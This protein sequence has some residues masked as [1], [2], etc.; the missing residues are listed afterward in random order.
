[1]KILFL[2]FDGVLVPGPLFRQKPRAYAFDPVCVGRLNKILDKL[3]DMQVV[4]SSTWRK[5]VPLNQ[6]VIHLLNSGLDL[7][8][9]RRVIGVTPCLERC[10]EQRPRLAQKYQR[11]EE[12]LEWL[13]QH[14][15]ACEFVCI[16]DHDDFDICGAHLVK[17][18]FEDGLTEAKMQEVFDK[19][20]QF[21]KMN[22]EYGSI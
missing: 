4:I 16:D 19:F 11:G 17:T 15:I 18:E 3:P 13:M 6:M 9:A 20:E 8:H 22:Q 21:A 2:D 12:C 1:M 10:I 14:K 7:N 5:G